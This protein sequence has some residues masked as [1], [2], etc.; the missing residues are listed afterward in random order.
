MNWFKS[1]WLTSEERQIL[2]EAKESKLRQLNQ[3]T[4]TKSATVLQEDILVP[5]PYSKLLYSNRN[6]TVIFPDG[7]IMT[8][9][10]IDMKIFEDVREA[11]SKAYIQTLLIGK[12][13]VTEELEVI[14]EKQLVK[15][16]LQIFRGSNDFIVTNGEVFLKGVN[17]A[18][19]PA[20][21]FS[22]IELLEKREA[23]EVGSDVRNEFSQ[24]KWD[25]LDEQYNALKMFWLKLALS[26]FDQS[27]ADLLTFI[28][29]NDVR[30]TPNGNLVLYRRIVSTGREDKSLTTFVSQ[31]YYDRKKQKK[32]H[33]H[34]RNYSIVRMDGTLTLVKTDEIPEGSQVLGILDDMYKN[35]DKLSENT[36]TSS[37]NRGQQK[38]KV[39]C[40]YKIPDDEIN[41]DNGNCAA[42]GLH[43][44]AVNYDY[45]GFG[46]TPVVVLVNP[47]KAITVPVGETGKMRTTEMFIAC[48]NDKGIG[49][50]F[51]EDALSS[52]DEEYHDLTL[53]ELEEAISSK[54]FVKLE[55]K[56]NKPK[57]QIVDI[58]KI[59]QLLEER[60]QTV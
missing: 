8:A 25:E 40:I 34:P 15:D 20:I 55:I 4:V 9:S 50:H 22:F 24:K 12:V 19:P 59:K 49:H 2:K 41:L 36:F 33:T 17:L 7:D 10:D 35:L 37:Y 42:G 28:K 26:P 23:Q 21:V 11:T 45:S 29:R 44:A 51:D 30:I 13:P 31:S 1:L 47:S 5:R 3:P 54:T 46:D 18:L 53:Q 60:V 27:R 58:E 16:N 14:K 56:D 52:F 39:G 6:I 38:I 48:I 57:L 43:A 32:S